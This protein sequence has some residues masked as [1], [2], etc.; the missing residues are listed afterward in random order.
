M[1]IFKRSVWCLITVFLAIMFTALMIAEGIA[2]EYSSWINNFLGINPYSVETT[3][4]DGVVEDTRYFKSDYEFS[5]SEGNVSY[6]HDAMRAHSLEVARDVATDGSVLLWNNGALPLGAG[7]NISFFG[8]DSVKY[9]HHGGGSGYVAI[10]T[11]KTLKSVCE[12]EEYGMHVN[13]TVWNAY[14][15]A[16][17]SRGGSSGIGSDKNYVDYKINE[18]AWNRIESAAKSSVKSY[19]NAVMVIARTGSENGDTDFKAYASDACFDDN[20][21]DLAKN[22]ADT[23]KGLIDLRNQGALDKVILLI[24]SAGAMQ[25]K[26]I[27]NYDI[28]ACLWVGMGGLASPEQIAALLSGK[29]NPYGR[30]TDTYVYD[31]DSAPATVNF[32]DFTFAKYDGVPPTTAYSHSN[33]YVVYQEGIYVGYR[34]YETRYEDCVMN[35]GSAASASGVKAGSGVWNYSDEVA[36]SFGYGASYTTFEY[37]KFKAVKKSNGD[38][39]VTVTVK[40]SGETYPGREVVQVYLQKPYTEYDKLNGIEKSS[41]ELVGFAKTRELAPG[42]SQEIKIIVDDYEFKTYDSYNK[43]TYIVEQGDYYLAVGVSAHDALNNILASKNYKVSDG[44]DYAGNA[45]FAEKFT[46]K[47]DFTTYSVSPFTQNEVTNRF[48]NA[49]INLYEGTQDQHITY[50]SRSDW[51]GTYPTPVNLTCTNAQMISDMQYGE[52][53][54]ADGADIMPKFGEVTSELGKLTLPMMMNLDYDDPTWND[55]LNQITW[56]DANMLVTDGANI[57][58]GIQDLIV[59]AMSTDDGPCG[60]RQTRV[61]ICDSMMAFPCNGLLA[62]TWDTELVEKLGEAFGMEIMHVGYTGIWGTGANIHRCAY[63]G[64]AW[65]Y[66]SEDGFISGKMFSAETQGLQ[67]RGAVVFT[68]HFA[69]NEQER[70][71]C[72]GTTWANEQTIREIYLKAFEAGVT[73]GKANGMMSSFTRIGCTWA[74]RHKGLLTDVLRGEWDFIGICE[75]DAKAGEHQW[76]NYANACA[77]LAGQDLWLG[78]GSKDAFD[79]YRDNATVCLAI[80]EACHRILYTRLHSNAMNGVSTNS[81]IVYTTPWWENA[82]TTVQIVSGILTGLSLVMTVL[83][84]VLNMKTNNKKEKINEKNV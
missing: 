63:S 55:F 69:L 12:S 56:E 79:D 39:E 44:M 23:L 75:T 22:E 43:R 20:Y 64:R 42:E 40:N 76:N 77:V 13:P 29:A 4:V 74:G 59:P 6:D 31:N 30:L 26:N 45:D 57:H 46:L 9:L 41:V 49:D 72:G 65:E 5:D 50:L 1:K 14:L 58:A 66:F 34:Y 21:M 17:Y 37:S 54:D 60:I 83:S 16:N 68:K 32:G 15:S 71:R 38:Y 78:S 81:V 10:T 18:V 47:D 35:K 11:D 67:K 24:N 36:Y 84:F 19:R 7:A 53:P 25:F 82:I 48:D 73:E 3:K 33:K 51:E 2:K 28:D 61:S 8:G 27:K 62:S 70:D 80:R 52:Y